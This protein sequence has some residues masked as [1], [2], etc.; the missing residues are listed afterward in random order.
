MKPAHRTIRREEQVKYRTGDLRNP[1][2]LVRSS[3]APVADTPDF[4]Q[5]LKVYAS[6][7]AKIEHGTKKLKGGTD[8]EVQA[9]HI[10]IIRFDGSLSVEASDFVVWADGLYTVVKT[11]VE[12]SASLQFLKIFSNY[13]APVTQAQIDSG[14]VVVTTLAEGEAPPAQKTDQPIIFQ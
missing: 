8:A 1:I 11:K 14:E 12:E 5:T 13:H 2:T 3:R 4:Q 10:F 7:F 9:T 6:P